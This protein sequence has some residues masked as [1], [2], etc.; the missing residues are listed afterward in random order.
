MSFKPGDI[1]YFIRYQFSDTGEEWPHF[2]LVLLPETATKYQ[3]SLLCCVVTSHSSR[4]KLTHCLKSS[5]Y[6]CFDHDSYAC[7]HRKDLVSKSGLGIEPQPRGAL[8]PNDIREAFKKIKKSIYAVQD[9]VSID[10]YLRATVISEWKFI[11]Q[12]LPP[13]APTNAT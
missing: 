6:P 3:N 1:P 9:L 7:F 11:V 10:P 8:S 13:E 12:S 4:S 5:E 2:A